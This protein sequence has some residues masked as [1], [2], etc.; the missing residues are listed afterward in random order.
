[1]IRRGLGVRRLLLLAVPL[2]LAGC[3]AAT[4]AGDQPDRTVGGDQPDQTVGGNQRRYQTSG[5]VLE[6]RDHGPELCLGV[7]ALS[8]PP[9]CDGLPIPNWRWNQVQ[10]QD[11]VGDSTWGEY[12]LVGT[13]DGA[14]FT[15]VQA[16]PIRPTPRPSPAERFAS[17]PKSPCPQP[18]DGWTL[19][20]PARSSQRHLEAADRAARAE[21]DF[22]GLWLSYLEPMGHNVAEAPGE[23]VLNVAFT[24]DLQRHETQLRAD[25]GGRLC[26]T[27]QQRTFRELRRTQDEL[28]GAAGRRLGLRVLVTAIDEYRNAV[29]IEVLVLDPPARQAL[30]AR[31]GAGA[32]DV[33]AMLIPVA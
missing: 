15:L 12:H 18:A 11:S 27:R 29:S 31:Y 2:L 22:A 32:V 33:T 1:V 28:Q 13:Y 26:V 21:P 10:V 17:E 6:N 19:P 16:D 14:S 24:G 20:D 5:T 23:F 4:P 8:L 25:W 9:Q 7:V 30:E 3:A